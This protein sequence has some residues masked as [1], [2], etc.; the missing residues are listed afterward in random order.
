MNEVLTKFPSPFP[1]P[2]KLFIDVL[3]IPFLTP[4]GKSDNTGPVSDKGWFLRRGHR[5]GNIVQRV[6]FGLPRFYYSVFQQAAQV[7]SLK[8]SK[9]PGQC[10]HLFYQ[11]PNLV[12][13]LLHSL[14]W[15]PVEQRT[16]YKWLPVEQRTEYKLL[17]LCFKTI[18]HQGPTYLSHLLHLGLYTPS[19][20]PRSSAN[21]Q[22]FRKPS[23]WPV[24][25]ASTTYN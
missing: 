14:C 2:F 4:T 15:L 12:T 10:C 5:H 20:Q 22:V 16:E 23:F 24:V 9:G 8:T 3:Y 7:S 25:Q 1:E 18:S 21:T 13:P 11:P 19:P 6:V 17:L